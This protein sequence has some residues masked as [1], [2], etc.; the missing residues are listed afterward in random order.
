MTEPKL[1][2]SDLNH[3]IKSAC[4]RLRVANYAGAMNYVPMVSWLLFLRLFDEREEQ[5]AAEADALGIAFT[6]ALAEPYRWR[7]WASP[8]GEQRKVLQQGATDALKNWVNQNLLPHLK[9]F[10]K[11]G[12][13]TTQQVIIAEVLSGVDF[14]RIDTDTNFRGVL[15]ILDAVRDVDDTHTFPLSQVYE[16]LLLKMGEKGNDGGQFFTPRDVVRAMVQ[17]IDPRT[18]ETVYDPC[19]GTGGFLAQAFE[20]MNRDEKTAAGRETLERRTFY[21]R[22]KEDSVFPITLANLVLHGIQEPHIWH[23]DT[24]TESTKHDALYAGAPGTFSVI[25]TNPPFGAKVGKEAQA[26]F[27]YKTGAT[28]ILFLQHIL[29]AMAAD[30]RC[31]MV[32]SEGAL[33]RTNEDAYVKTKRKLLDTCD[34]WCVLSLPGGVFTAAGAGV[35]TSLLFF[36]KGK[37]TEKIWYYDLSHVKVGKTTPMTLANFAEFFR[38]LP[39]RGDGDYSWTVDFSARKASARAQA[40]PLRAEAKPLEERAERL[41]AEAKAVKKTRPSESAERES[42]AAS[43][44]AQARALRGDADTIEANVYDLKAVNPRAKAAATP[45]TVADLLERIADGE[46]DAQAALDRLRATLH[47]V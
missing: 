27:A 22:E 13:A 19:C 4:D 32:L 1:R 47:T 3:K 6:P 46:R 16:S 30:G 11:S 43:L 18:G 20:Y 23:G 34:L 37:P 14:V 33:F 7:D 5:E 2:L 26:K 40:E 9:G 24:L 21:G 28:E 10:D 39:T 42:E 8:G 44:E 38:L 25:L 15:D 12:S 45:V 29:D 36:S 31:G 35:K 17:A 41:R